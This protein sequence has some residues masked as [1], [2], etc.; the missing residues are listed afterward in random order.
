[1]ISSSLALAASIALSFAS[2]LGSGNSACRSLASTNCFSSSTPNPASVSPPSCQHFFAPSTSSASPLSARKSSARK[3]T[4]KP[5][6]RQNAALILL[7]NSHVTTPLLSPSATNSAATFGL[8]GTSI[9]VS[10]TN[11][12]NSKYPASISAAS[13][14]PP[15]DKSA[16]ILVRIIAIDVACELQRLGYQHRH[17]VTR[18]HLLQRFFHL[19]L[20]SSEFCIS[21]IEG[22]ANKPSRRSKPSHARSVTSLSA[23][24]ARRSSSTM[25]PNNHKTKRSVDF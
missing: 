9:A 11:S 4:W 7:T 16:I 15:S 20:C 8:P 23:K 3:R 14:K 12:M 21:S 19:F 1:M 13:S 5:V 6:S 17:E 25:M 24:E 18:L 10:S 22:E 2:A